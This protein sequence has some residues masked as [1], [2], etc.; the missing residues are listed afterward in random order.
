MPPA[1]QVA[2]LTCMNVGPTVSLNSGCPGPNWLI[3][4]G[5]NLPARRLG[6]RRC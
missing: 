1:R 6:G 3:A 4:L 5:N 2:V